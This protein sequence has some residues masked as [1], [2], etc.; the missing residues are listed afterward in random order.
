MSLDL[1]LPIFVASGLALAALLVTFEWPRIRVYTYSKRLEGFHIIEIAFVLG[2]GGA[3]VAPQGDLHQPPRGAEF[4]I[5]IT[6]KT[7]NF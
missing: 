5:Y 2:A 3:K 1:A 6:S 7:G 4:V